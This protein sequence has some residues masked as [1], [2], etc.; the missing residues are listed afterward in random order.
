MTKDSL[1]QEINENDVCLVYFGGDNCS[2]CVAMKPKIREIV[3]RYEGMKMIEIDINENQHL[4]GEF[5]VL[6][7]PV[8]LVYVYG[9]EYIREARIISIPLFEEKLNRIY[10]LMK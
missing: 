1:M 9:R 2:V 5:S 7:L 4:A 6:T 8:I 10:E 3:S